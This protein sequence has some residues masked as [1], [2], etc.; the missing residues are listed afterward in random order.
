VIKVIHFNNGS[1]GGVFSV[2]KNLLKYKQH[3]EFE[4][5][6][7]YLIEREHKN[8]FEIPRLEGAKTERI[9]LYNGK[10]NLH[11]T[12]KKLAEMIPDDDSILIAHDWMELRLYEIL[13]LK[14]PLIYFLHG[15]FD[16]YY[17]LSILHSNIIDWH[18]CV[19][20]VIER[21][22]KEISNISNAIF[23]R[24]PVRDVTVR[25]KQFFKV[26]IAYYVF[27]LRL[28]MKQFNLLPLIEKELVNQGCLVEW[29]IAGGGMELSDVEERWGDNFSDRV[30][31]YGRLDQQG[32]DTL[33]EK[34]NVFLLPSTIEGLPVSLIESMKSGL[35][36]MTSHWEGA[37][38]DVL[39]NNEN[40]FYLNTGD[41]IGYASRIK[42]LLD[43]PDIFKTMSESAINIV[44]DKFNPFDNAIKYED[45]FLR[46]FNLENKK[47][48][49]SNL[50]RL[51]KKHIPNF[52]VMILRN[53]KAF[54]TS[55][56]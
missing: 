45:V 25:R 23:L 54:I 31:F 30:N 1:G 6:V 13:K 3:L 39:I 19:S 52:I 22:L 12:S 33:I 4:Y 35:V 44:N 34:C 7:I 21:R 11:Y 32:I 51:D 5:H 27:D 17:N 47:Y 56:A 9:L 41:Y 20:P 46:K 50:S 15:N 26:K 48:D 14:N 55:V 42:Y 28:E 18:I 49:H 38:E 36:P 29:F 37:V 43:N 8:N 2:I 53:L 24:F 16:Y 10:W 40:G